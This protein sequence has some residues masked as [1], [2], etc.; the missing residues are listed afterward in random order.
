M[1]TATVVKFMQKTAEDRLLRE[2]L[3]TLLG[4]GDGDISSEAAL[5]ESESAAL[6][7]EHAPTVANFAAQYGFE[8]SVDELV[9]VV[10]ALE[11]HQAGALTDEV[12]VQMVGVAVPKSLSPAQKLIKF[13]SKT[14]FG[15]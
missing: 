7:G 3:E 12:F 1:A 5:D 9:T 6:K 13:L 8:F 15:Y 4:V 11:K 2:Q 14:Y 10:D